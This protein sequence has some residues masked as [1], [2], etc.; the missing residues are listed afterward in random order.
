MQLVKLATPT[1]SK[2]VSDALQFLSDSNMKGLSLTKQYMLWK[3]VPYNCAFWLSCSFDIQNIPECYY[4]YY[5]TSHA[6]SGRNSVPSQIFRSAVNIYSS[7]FNKSVRQLIALPRL[8]KAIYRHRAP[9]HLIVTSYCTWTT[10]GL[11]LVKPL[12]MLLYPAST[13]NLKTHVKP[14]E[15]HPFS[16]AINTQLKAHFNHSL[17]QKN[18]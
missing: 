10:R 1:F 17:H 5:A 18:P 4:C 11:S 16:I 8:G 7:G 3:D 14:T 9:H 12:C 13:W 2:S 15:M 6:S